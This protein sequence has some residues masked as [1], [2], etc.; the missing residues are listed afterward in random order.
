MYGSTLQDNILW[1]GYTTGGRITGQTER[2]SE[3]FPSRKILHYFVIAP[4]IS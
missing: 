4:V 1:Y 3:R 2:T